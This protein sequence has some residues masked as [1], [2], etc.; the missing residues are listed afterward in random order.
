M[1][2]LPEKKQKLPQLWSLCMHTAEGL[3]TGRM[4]HPPL[5]W[6]VWHSC[7][8]LQVF[9]FICELYQPGREISALAAGDNKRH[10]M[11]ASGSILEQIIGVHGY[12][13]L[14]SYPCAL[15]GEVKV[16]G[17]PG[18]SVFSTCSSWAPGKCWEQAEPQLASCLT[19][20]R[21]CRS[22]LLLEDRTHKEEDVLI[23]S[24]VL[25]VLMNVKFCLSQL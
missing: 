17:L 24:L 1:L 11:E 23:S 3:G 13:C 8:E 20:E 19:P 22:G 7:P 18:V 14:S 16:M 9:D 15:I 12:T 21:S 2:A 10:R 4:A 6:E 5:L 25:E